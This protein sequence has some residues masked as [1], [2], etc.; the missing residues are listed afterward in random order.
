MEQSPIAKRS[1]KSKSFSNVA[2]AYHHGDLRNALIEASLKLIAT[3]GPRGFSM[4]EACRMAKVSPTAA[5]RHFADKEA[6]LEEIAGRGFSLL[7]MA[8]SEVHE[9]F[10]DEDRLVELACVYVEFSL[11][12]PV[13]F[14]VM[15]NTGLDKTKPS[16]NPNAKAAFAPLQK[17]AQ[18]EAG[19]M[20]VWAA[21]H[22][23]AALMLDAS[24]GER[25]ERLKNKKR[26]RAI[27]EM[28]LSSP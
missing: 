21:A 15:F 24:P 1:S 3:D 9:K 4:S 25:F 26:Y 12:Q 28:L 10:S 20:A 14:T 17:A 2:T 11:K 5:Y 18:S 8:L 19:A 13:L 27:L 23:V 7:G 6:I 22:G 16:I